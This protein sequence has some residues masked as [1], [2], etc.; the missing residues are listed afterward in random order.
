MGA[1]VAVGEVVDPVAGGDHLLHDD[2]RVCRCG[3]V[4]ARQDPR[5]R[6]GHERRAERGAA[7]RARTPRS[8]RPGRRARRRAPAPRT[9]RPRAP[10]RCRRGRTRAYASIGWPVGAPLSLISTSA[11][12]STAVV[13][14]VRPQR[15][16]GQVVAQRVVLI[17][18][19]AADPD[20]HRPRRAREVRDAR[21][22]RSRL[23]RARGSGRRPVIALL[24]ADPGEDLPRDLVLRPDLLVD[25]Q[26]AGR[27][28][29]DRQRPRA[30]HR[31]RCRSTSR[32]SR[33]SAARRRRRA[34]AGTRPPR[35]RATR[36]P[37]RRVTTA[38]AAH[39]SCTPLTSQRP[40]CS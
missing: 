30:R 9:R 7:R 18:R 3:R 13:G 25:P 38:I 34:A 6:P 12:S 20:L 28:V 15:R 17:A 26:E 39:P 27:D 4:A 23:R 29:T 1:A 36:T 5:L 11:A 40:V 10:S 35:P 21:A 19:G 14:I 16:V 31:P 32:R 8:R 22:S 37:R 33:P 24:L 2:R